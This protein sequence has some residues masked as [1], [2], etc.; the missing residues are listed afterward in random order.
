[1]FKLFGSLVLCVSLVF[2]G[3]LNAEAQ[4]TPGTILVV[5][6]GDENPGK[7]FAVDPNTGNRT[8]IS[9]FGN[10]SQGPLG[11]APRGVEVTADGT[12]YVADAL[13]RCG[14]DP[15]SRFGGPRRGRG[16]CYKSDNRQ[17]NGRE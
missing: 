6:N 11:V 16:V 3:S 2:S 12:I 1:M 9:D 14:R 7:L 17:S 4:L 13:A 5:D 10:A 15:S 8:L